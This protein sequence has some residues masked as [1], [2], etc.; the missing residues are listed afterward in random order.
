MINDRIS[1]G[2]KSKKD[3]CCCKLGDAAYNVA[4]LYLLNCS[5][6]VPVTVTPFFK[7]T[8]VSTINRSCTSKVT[9]SRN[10]SLNLWRKQKPS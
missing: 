7:A 9:K 3:L 5:L 4:G 1:K 6:N 8:K 2:L 10:L